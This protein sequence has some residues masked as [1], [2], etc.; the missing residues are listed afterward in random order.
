MSDLYLRC[1]IGN[2]WQQPFSIIYSLVSVYFQYQEEASI[3]NCV[4][5]MSMGGKPKKVT[6]GPPSLLVESLYRIIFNNMQIYCLDALTYHP[7]P[8]LRANWN[9]FFYQESL[10]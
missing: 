4:F 6:D 8:F 7:P 5:S 10:L 3:K 2:V 9:H 1:R